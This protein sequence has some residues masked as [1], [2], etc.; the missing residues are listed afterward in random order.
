M[1]K[2]FP[3]LLLMVVFLSFCSPKQEREK[4]VLYP[5]QSNQKWGYEDHNGNIIIDYKY[6]E[7]GPFRKGTAMVLLNNK[8]MLVDQTGKE[9]SK[10]Y[11][12]IEYINDSYYLA[13][14]FG[15]RDLL[16][17]KGRLIEDSLNDAKLY[18]QDTT[19]VL[20]E[21]SIDGK[22]GYNFLSKENK[23]VLPVWIDKLSSFVFQDND[24]PLDNAGFKKNE[25]AVL[26]SF[27]RNNKTRYA[28]MSDKM[29]LITD[30]FFDNGVSMVNGYGYLS[31]N[32]E[33]MREDEF[34]IFDSLGKN[35]CRIK[36]E[37]IT[38]IIPKYKLVTVGTKNG[39]CFYDLMTGEKI[40]GP[41]HQIGEGSSSGGWGLSFGGSSVVSVTHGSADYKGFSDGMIKFY[42]TPL[43][44]GFIDS[45][46]K[47]A[48][49]PRF[50]SVF[51]FTEGLARVNRFNRS[52]KKFEIGYINKKGDLVIPYL[53]SSAEE[54]KNGK[55]EVVTPDGK[56]I[57]IDK[58]GKEVK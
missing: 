54:F 37:R 5:V 56:K 3:F 58:T 49:S 15:E 31:I 14:E 24:F 28:Y 40:S 42:L 35:L 17:E 55:A 44:G 19:F 36:A 4:G 22:R 32:T 10:G 33:D 30:T 27:E 9:L 48:I 8:Y 20:L 29:K 53:Y 21:K 16:D 50:E 2:Q 13:G 47:V 39:D 25:P 7:A 46:G 34:Y 11:K 52:T 12:T 45:T 51:D 26:V 41:F 1:K 43:K 38:E 6:E 23:P 18:K 57:K